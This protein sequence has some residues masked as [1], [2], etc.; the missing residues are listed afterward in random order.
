[1]RRRNALLFV[2]LLFASA[3]FAVYPGEY[4]LYL[5]LLGFTKEEIRNLRD[6]G[7]VSHSIQDAGRGEYGITAAHVINVPP[8]FL[9]DYYSA[10]ENYVTLRNFR[11]VGK[12]SPNPRAQDLLSLRF[13]DEELR[14][15]AQCRQ[16]TCDLHLSSEE[17]ARIPANVDFK[18]ENQRQQ[19][20]ELIRSILLARL[21]HYQ[22]DGP[23]EDVRSQAGR[24]PELAPYFVRAQEYLLNYPATRTS[25]SSDFYYW[26]RESPGRHPTITLHHVFIQPVD[27]DFVLLDTTFY[28]TRYFRAGMVVIHYVKYAD[29]GSPATLVVYEERATTDLTAMP[30][31]SFVRNFYSLSLH[32]QLVSRLKREAKSVENRYR[33]PA[34][35]T[36]PYRLFTGDQR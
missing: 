1:M 10:I 26:L 28:S 23:G 24:F 16:L 35:A 12:F 30:F 32:R 9:K 14:S 15:F 17:M 20:S 29:R 34:Y 22:K 2:F 33:A 27:E 19:I 5:R 25:E 8:Y 36:F 7:T 18:S 3:L 6:G 31:Q 13:S 4:P 21:V 11:D